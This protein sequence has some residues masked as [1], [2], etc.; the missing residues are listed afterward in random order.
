M[1][2]FFNCPETLTFKACE[3]KNSPRLS[4]LK[5][6]KTKCFIQREKKK[7]QKIKSKLTKTCCPLASFQN[8]YPLARF[9]NSLET[10][11]IFQSS[12]HFSTITGVIL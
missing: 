9:T 12:K 11:E 2:I 5:A 7:K 1:V 8:G 10:A 3:P 4:K 6:L